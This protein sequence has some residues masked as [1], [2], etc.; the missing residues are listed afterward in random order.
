MT[1]PTLKVCVVSERVGVPVYAT[2]GA[3]GMDLQADLADK[4]TLHPGE[5]ATIPCGIKLAVPEGYEA[6]LRPRSG[7]ASKHGVTM[8]NTPATIDEDYRGIVHVILIN[9]GRESFSVNPGER[10]AQMVIA[11]VTRVETVR[12]ESADELG[13]TARGE[14]G[15]GSTGV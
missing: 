15:M 10:I 5:R 2:A 3:A 1:Q 11:P 9:H 13:V 4:I 6:Q 12:V 7:L 8:V 14:G